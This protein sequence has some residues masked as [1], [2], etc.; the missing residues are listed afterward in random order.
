[1]TT[2]QQ[3][4]PALKVCG[5]TR[6][7]DLGLCLRLGASFVGVIVEIPRSPRSLG[8]D[9]AVRLLRCAGG[10][11]VVVTESDDV[12]ALADLA[13]RVPL[14]AIQLHGAQPPEVV[15]ELRATLTGLVTY[16]TAPPGIWAALGMS[17]EAAEAEAGLEALGALGRAYAA[18]GAARIVLDAQVAGR[19]GGTGVPV[20]WSVAARFI[21]ACPAPVLL[22][23]G[24]APENAPAAFRAA[25]PWG[26]D[27]SSGVEASPGVKSPAKL[28]ALFG[29]LP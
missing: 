24:L 1:M 29:A 3:P 17:A 12:A 6:V 26:L 2:L 27:L 20:D 16:P 7:A 11:G 14:A 22:A 13:A 4:Q 8:R 9:Q 19:S 25:A 10:R 15:E 28:R 21:R 5:L 23:G 18:A